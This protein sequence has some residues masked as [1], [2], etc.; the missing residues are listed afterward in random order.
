M[1]TLKRSKLQ[2][3]PIRTLA[4]ALLSTCLTIPGWAAILTVNDAGDTSDATPGDGICATAGGV[5]TLRAAVEEANALA[6]ADNIHFNIGG[7]GAVTINKSAANPDITVTSEVHIDGYTQP[8]ATANTLTLGSNAILQVRYDGAAGSGNGL[9]FTAGSNNSTLRGLVLT[10]HTGAA[11]VIDQA[12]SIGIT[13]NFIG[14]DAAGTDLHN[15]TGVFA[16]DNADNIGIG[17]PLPADR[18]VISHNLSDGVVIGNSPSQYNLV[19]NN[20]IGTAP[21]GVSPRRNGRYG[22]W[23]N[24]AFHTGIRD[25]VISPS[26]AAILISNG[27]ADQTTVTG[28]LIGVGADGVTSIGGGATGDGVVINSGNS[29]APNSV[30]IGGINPGEGNIIATLGG[31]AVRVD[32]INPAHVAPS[33]VSIRGNRIY[34]NTG[35]GIDLA[36]SATGIDVG[37]VNANDPMDVDNGVNAFQNFPVPTLASTNGVQT[38]VNFT[39]GSYALGG[40]FHID[41]YASS[42]CDANGHGEGRVYLGSTTVFTD[43]GGS[44]SGTLAGLPATT[45]GHYIT[46]VATDQSLFSNSSEFSAC[47]PVSA[48]PVVAGGPQSVP[49]LGLL[50]QLLTVLGVAAA[51]LMARRVRRTDIT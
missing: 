29:G 30:T 19:R 26:T 3:T 8:G 13:G 47:L 25:N 39:Y 33:N 37:T 36:D 42:T 50:G 16:L 6:G 2:S 34:G 21:D 15:G 24:G 22:I 49:A 10:R 7:G 23:I 46:L 28:N 14:T 48:G 17:G 45:V 40:P 32:R 27:G 35:M 18:N 9:Y 41:A 11:L 4:V 5:C 51:G 38:S 20:Y 12:I 43:I 31:T 44:A 1:K